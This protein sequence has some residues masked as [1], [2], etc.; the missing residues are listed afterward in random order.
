MNDPLPV[1]TLP[2]CKQC[3]L[4]KHVLDSTGMPYVVVDLATDECAVDTVKQ[5]G[6]GAAP[7]VVDG[8]ASWSGFRPDQIK[9]LV[10]ARSDE[11]RTAPATAT[12][13]G[14]HSWE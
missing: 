11:L 8:A 14:S 5:L 4:T 2:G 10:A 9:A 3:D 6:Y 13:E 12:D 1:Y 7:V